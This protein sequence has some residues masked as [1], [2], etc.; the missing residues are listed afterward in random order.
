MKV[1]G[2][3]MPKNTRPTTTAS[4]APPEM[5][6]IAGSATGLR[7]TACIPAPASAS[8]E[9]TTIASI[10]RGTRLTIAASPIESAEPNSAPP[11]SSMDTSRLPKAME[12]PNS[13]TSTATPT[14]RRSSRPVVCVRLKTA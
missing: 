8:A 1:D 7:V 9:P 11:I 13:T 5:P 4:D 14:A 3:L 6:R 12:T 2:P 10:V